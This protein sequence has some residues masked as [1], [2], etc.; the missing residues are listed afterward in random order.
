[1][2]KQSDRPQ[3]F[4]EKVG[5]E[6]TRSESSETMFQMWQNVSFGGRVSLQGCSMPILSQR[7][8][9]HEQLFRRKHSTRKWE[10]KPPAQNR[11]KPCFRCG[12]TSHSADECHY[13]DAQCRYCHKDG[14]IMSNCFAKQK[15][16]KGKRNRTHQLTAPIQHLAYSNVLW[17]RS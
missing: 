13:K 8:T 5:E 4:N 2:C 7:W 16:E 14:H 9:H 15:A 17:T 10:K 11:Q 6:T 3:A 1:M 12:K